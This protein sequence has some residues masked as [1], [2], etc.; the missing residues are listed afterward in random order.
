MQQRNDS[1]EDDLKSELEHVPVPD[2]F[3]WTR[4]PGES[5]KT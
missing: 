5:S 1:G 2:E 3:S 4:L